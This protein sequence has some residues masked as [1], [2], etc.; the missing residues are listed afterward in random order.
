M[1]REDRPLG[2]TILS[3]YYV[4]WGV[5]TVLWSLLTS[6]LGAVT[7]CLVP[8]LLVGGVLGLIQG[9]LS[10]VLGLAFYSG[11]DFARI[12]VMGLAL[13]GIVLGVLGGLSDGFG[14][15]RLI[16]IAVNTF[17]LFYVNSER[18]QRFFATN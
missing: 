4:L 13:L 15:G 11:K 2:V 9:V 14:V 1:V 12:L 8:G 5:A 7:A 3:A 6:V 18:V 17:V 16:S 10:V